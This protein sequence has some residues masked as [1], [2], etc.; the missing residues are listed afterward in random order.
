M[1]TP[2][3]LLIFCVTCLILWVALI[4]MD[5]RDRNLVFSP[6]TRIYRKHVCDGKIKKEYVA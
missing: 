6:K 1:T 3:A 2:I 4:V 5:K